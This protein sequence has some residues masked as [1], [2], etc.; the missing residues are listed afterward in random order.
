MSENDGMGDRSS[1]IITYEKKYLSFLFGGNI[2]ILCPKQELNG[3]L[4]KMFPG[5][6]DVIRMSVLEAIVWWECPIKSNKE[7]KKYIA[8]LKQMGYNV[9]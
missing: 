1:Y 4:W 8:K 7:A 9:C 5:L 3:E 6:Y 2:K